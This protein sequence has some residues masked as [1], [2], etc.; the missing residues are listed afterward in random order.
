MQS[1]IINVKK[2]D[3]QLILNLNK[4]QLIQQNSFLIFE[5][6]LEFFKLV[7]FVFA[8]VSDF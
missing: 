5:L 7:S 6:E 4:N 1:E 2:F 3:S 8:V